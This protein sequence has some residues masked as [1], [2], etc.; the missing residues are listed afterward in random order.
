[1]AHHAQ[2]TFDVK[3]TPLPPTPDGIKRMSFDKQLHGDLEAVSQ[4]EMLTAGDFKSGRAGYVAMELV[5]GRLAGRNGTFSLQHNAQ[6]S[7]S[8]QVL[9]IIVTPGS[10]T[11]ELQGLEGIFVITIAEGKHSYTFDYDLP[12]AD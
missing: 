8:G 9:E 6:I 10:G 5:T 4:G 11:E 3:V 1:M 2:G 12:N 7:A